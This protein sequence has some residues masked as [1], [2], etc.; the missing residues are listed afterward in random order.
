MYILQKTLGQW[1]GG[2]GGVVVSGPVFVYSNL[3]PANPV[4]IS[5]IHALFRTKGKVHAVFI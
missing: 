5:K 1:G 2:G 4:F 3:K